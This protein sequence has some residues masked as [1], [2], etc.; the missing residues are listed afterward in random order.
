VQCIA[1]FFRLLTC[2]EEPIRKIVA[3]AQCGDY[4]Q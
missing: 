3:Q 2:L 1:C 4:A